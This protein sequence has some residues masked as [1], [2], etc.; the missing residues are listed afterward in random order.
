MATKYHINPRFRAYGKAR[1][2]ITRRATNE[3]EWQSQWREPMN[4]Y[5]FTSPEGWQFCFEYKVDDFAAEVGFFIDVLGFAVRAFSTSYAQFASPD[6]RICFNVLSAGDG[7]E[8]TPPDSIRLYL[9]VHDLQKASAQL[10]NRGIPFEA[11]RAIGSLTHG[12]Q[13]GYFRSPHGVC[14]EL[15]SE[16]EGEIPW[17]DDG[18]DSD[19][20]TLYDEDTDRKI[21]QLLGLSE[22]RKQSKDA[23]EREPDLSLHLFDEEAGNDLDDEI[24]EEDEEDYNEAPIKESIPVSQEPVRADNRTNISSIPWGAE[25]QT[26]IS[27]QVNRHSTDVASRK[28]T[29]SWSPTKAPTKTEPVYLK[30]EE[31]LPE[32]DI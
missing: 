10:H 23:G 14:I 18:E 25:R 15:R 8:S 21:D 11:I 32:E 6:G 28:V 7:E 9:N 3:Q 24:M 31:E 22:N 26:R 20:E 4:D 29:S 16:I 19:R 17:E 13:S 30:I 12:I 1:I 5:P 27:R 2:D